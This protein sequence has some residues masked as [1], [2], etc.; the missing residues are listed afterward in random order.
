MLVPMQDTPSEV[1]VLGFDCP[2]VERTRMLLDLKG[3]EH[4]Y[5]SLTDF[6]TAPP[7]FLELNPLGKVPTLVDGDLTVG[8]VGR[9]V[10]ARDTRVLVEGRDRLE[11][12][13]DPD[14]NEIRV[15]GD[16]VLR[17]L[18]VSQLSFV[19]R[20][21]VRGDTTLFAARRRRKPAARNAVAPASPESGS[22]GLGRRENITQL[23]RRSRCRPAERCFQRP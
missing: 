18:S 11:A 2:F 16:L 5:R 4:T 21:F 13:L 7:W 14:K 6:K 17:E 1:E 23:V 8:P 22:A 15:E 12:G 10:L 20:D 19:Q 3:V 9:L